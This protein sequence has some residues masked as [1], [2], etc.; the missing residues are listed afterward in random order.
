[1]FENPLSDAICGEWL[2]GPQS[3]ARSESFYCSSEYLI[4]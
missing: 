4:Y 1:M 3:C 2:H